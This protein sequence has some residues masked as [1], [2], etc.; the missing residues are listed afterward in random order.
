MVTEMNEEEIKEENEGEIIAKKHSRRKIRILEKYLKPCISFSEKYGNFAYIDTHGGT[1]KIIDDE[2]GEK[3]DG[4]VLT[5][6]KTEPTWPCYCVE[7]DPKRFALLQKNTKNIPN[8]NL[9]HGD[10]NEKIDDILDEIP[11]GEKFVFCFIDP[12]KLLYKSGRQVKYQIT[13][14]TIEKIAKFPRT[15]ILMTFLVTTVMR[16]SGSYHKNPEG[17]AMKKI[18]DHLTMLF[19]SE[20]W[21]I[22]GKGDYRKFVRLFIDERF[23]K[24]KYKGAVLIRHEENRGPLY[25][26]VFGSDS[27]V[28]GRIMRDIMMREWLDKTKTYPLSKYNKTQEE[29]LNAEYP[30]ALFVFEDD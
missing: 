21:K 25:Y 1:G 23:K 18:G 30:L 20:K 9:F 10:C 27:R 12:N 5:F 15:E 26:L 4:S 22:I 2:T 29:W 8:V 16:N 11:P 17:S 14:E 28:G 6:A 13:W 7:I 19:G 24:F 3:V